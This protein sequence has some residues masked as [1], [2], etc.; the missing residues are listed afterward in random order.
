MLPIVL[1]RAPRG[2]LII[3]ITIFSND[4]NDEILG[5]N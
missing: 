1:F 3:T 4:D 5:N 2:D